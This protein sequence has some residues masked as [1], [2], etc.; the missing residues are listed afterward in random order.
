MHRPPVAGVK[1]VIRVAQ[2][3]EFAVAKKPASRPGWEGS[4]LAIGR[5]APERDFSPD[6]DAIAVGANLVAGDSRDPFD[7]AVGGVAIAAL[8]RIVWR[9]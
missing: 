2:Q 3:K 4:T 5:L 9:D 1:A 8:A 7:E 6:V